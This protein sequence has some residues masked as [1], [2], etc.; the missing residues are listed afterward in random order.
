MIQIGAVL[1]DVELDGD[2]ILNYEICPPNC[3]LCIESC[4]QKALNGR[5]VNQRLCRPLSN[6]RTEKGYNLQKCNLCRRIC[7]NCLGIKSNHKT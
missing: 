6:Y 2:S 7:P 4:P 1:V 3:K 5:T